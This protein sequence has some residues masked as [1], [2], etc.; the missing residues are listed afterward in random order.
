MW[1]MERLDFV[2]SG[3]AGFISG[4]VASLA[5]EL[6]IAEFHSINDVLSAKDFAESRSYFF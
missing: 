3:F 2:N 4:V 6:Q 1:L 5:A